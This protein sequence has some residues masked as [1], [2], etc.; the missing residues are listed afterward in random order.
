MTTL[1]LS[2][3]SQD[4]IV[5]AAQLILSGQIIVIPTDT[6]YGLAMQPHNLQNI[7]RL[8]EMRQRDPEPALPFLLKDSTYIKKFARVNRVARQLTRRF[9]PGALTIILPPSLNLPQPLRSQPV[10][11]RVPN[12]PLLTSL[13]DAVGG[14]LMVT[15]AIKSGYSPA[16]TAQE[17]AAF[18]NQEVALILDGGATPFGVPS[19]IV[20]CIHR[21]PRILRRGL[22]SEAQIKSALRSAD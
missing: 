17:A 5:Q 10:A 1:I 15:G 19:T 13:L 12:F 7:A 14:Y 16:I 20:D 6:V 18:F 4:A 21:P 2:I 3:R 9:W 11:L 22:I 8:Y